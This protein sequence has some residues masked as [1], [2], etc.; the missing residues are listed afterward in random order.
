MPEQQL[1]SALLSNGS[2]N[3]L[4]EKEKNT[5]GLVCRIPM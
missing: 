3:D 5:D 1:F 2:K 4:P